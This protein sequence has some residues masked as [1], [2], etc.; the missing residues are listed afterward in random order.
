MRPYDDI[1]FD[2]TGWDLQGEIEGARVWWNS[3]GD[4]IGVYYFAIPPDIKADLQSIDGVR[5]FYRD[6]IA[7]DGLGMIEVEILE[8]DGC[9]A[10]RTIFKSPQQPTGMTYLGS[11][12]LPFRDFSYVMKV[13]CRETGMTGV[14]DAAVL[15]QMIGA[16]PG[17]VATGSF[18]ANP[19]LVARSIRSRY[20]STADAELGRR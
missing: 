7:P 17:H 20:R 18:A 6:S 9:P 11:I 12:T 16:R 13:Q 19:R 5:K 4:G 2:D 3:A 8:V 1:S 14:R 15:S 10:V